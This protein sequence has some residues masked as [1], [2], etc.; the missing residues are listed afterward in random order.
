MLICVAGWS[1]SV[2]MSTGATCSASLLGQWRW[3][4]LGSIGLL[5]KAIPIKD[6]TQTNTEG[7][8]LVCG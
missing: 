3:G 4:S 5:D 1:V 8:F 6:K 2:C 7:Y